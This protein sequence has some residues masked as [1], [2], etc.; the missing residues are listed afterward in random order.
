MALVPL[1]LG[2]WAAHLL[3]HLIT[4]RDVDGWDELRVTPRSARL[5]GLL[6]LTFWVGVVIFGRWIGFT[7]H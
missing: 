3:F 5:A 2:M 4:W 7:V 1:G 6:S